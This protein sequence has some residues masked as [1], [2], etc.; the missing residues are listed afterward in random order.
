[1]VGA[2]VVN[3]TQQIHASKQRLL[4]LAVARLRQVKHARCWR[5]LALN[6]SINTVH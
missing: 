6:R 2:K 5:T 4:L 3:T 1:M